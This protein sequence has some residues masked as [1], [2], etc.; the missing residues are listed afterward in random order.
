VHDHRLAQGIGGEFLLAQVHDACALKFVGAVAHD[1]Q[2]A[3]F[4]WAVGT[5]RGEDQVSAWTQRSV[6]HCEIAV[7]VAAHHRLV[8][9]RHQR[10]TVHRGDGLDR[11]GVGN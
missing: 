1:R 10:V 9:R 4:G 7:P 2:A 3:A 5:E 6:K 8:V 11:L